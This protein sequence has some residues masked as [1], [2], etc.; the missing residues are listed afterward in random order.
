MAE[1][2]VSNR[3]EWDTEDILVQHMHVCEK[4][5]SSNMCGLLA[6]SSWNKRSQITGG[7]T[8]MNQSPSGFLL[9]FLSFMNVRERL[10]NDE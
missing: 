5:P 4:R 7:I 3:S 1:K 6:K 10:S 9:L 8:N 2:T